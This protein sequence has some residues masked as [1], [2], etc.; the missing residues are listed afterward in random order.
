MGTPRFAVY[1]LEALERNDLVPEVVFC[2]PDKPVGRKKIL[3]PPEAKLWALE[4]NIPVEQPHNKHE[5]TEALRKYSVDVSIVAAFNIIITPEALALPK[6]GTLNVHPSLLPK[7]R[8]PA[9]IQQ[10]LLD[11]DT[12]AGVCIMEL[13]EEIDHGPLLTC[14]EYQLN[15]TETYLE[16]EKQLATEGGN[17]LANILPQWLTNAHQPTPQNHAHATHTTRFETNDAQVDLETESAID[18]DRKV[19]ALNPEPTAWTL[20]ETKHGPKRIKIL[21][22]SIQDGKYVPERVVPEGK[23]EMGWEDFLR[24]NR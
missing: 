19:R 13:D 21:S 11:G 17:L 12:T 8:G 20:L 23:K 22:G 6:H 14:T 24:G 4:R 10:T 15:G 2:A 16:L 7:H 3:T 9:P 5:L 1:V 18:I